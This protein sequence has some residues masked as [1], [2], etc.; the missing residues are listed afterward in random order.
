MPVAT[1]FKNA[2]K[3][4]KLSFRRTITAIQLQRAY[5]VLIE[6]THAYEASV[7]RVKGSM[8]LLSMLIRP[9][10]KPYFQRLFKQIKNGAEI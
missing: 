3:K 2:M 5:S 9:E 1:L 8:Y 7:R 10:D 4:P 6:E